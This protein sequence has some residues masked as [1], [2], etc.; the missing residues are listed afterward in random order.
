[1]FYT[2]SYTYASN[3]K[4][5]IIQVMVDETG[6]VSVGRD[7]I[8]IDD[9]ARYIQERLFKS[10]LGTGRMYSKILLAKAN[11]KVPDIVLDVVLKE[12]K[13][14]QQRALTELSLQK[15]ENKYE[16]LSDKKK[17][18]LKKVFPVLFQKKFM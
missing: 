6:T 18:K 13:E 3:S 9:L 8:F 7:T 2:N 17:A 14:G 11:N 10:Y 1:M 15:Y 12:I 16:S 4:E 5:K